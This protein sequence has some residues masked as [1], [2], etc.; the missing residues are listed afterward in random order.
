MNWKGGGTAGVVISRRVTTDSRP[1]R[2]SVSIA[3]IAMAPPT[4]TAAPIAASDRQCARDG[5]AV[6]ITGASAGASASSI[7]SRAD[8]A[9]GNRRLRSFSRQ[10]R[11][12]L[13][14]GAGVV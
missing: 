2:W 3:A 4:N 7:S 13:R 12:N 6:A 8:A 11:S 1:A 9:S 10:R 5:D 14:M